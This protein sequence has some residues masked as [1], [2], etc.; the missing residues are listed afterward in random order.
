MIIDL[1]MSSKRL[2]NFL[3][4][5]GLL[6]GNKIK[7]GLDIPPW[8]N[9]RKTWQRACLRGLFDT[10]GCTYIDHHV[11]NGR[12]Y[13]NI[14][15]SFT[16]YSENLYDNYARI[17]RLLM[18]SPTQSAGKRVLLRRENEV[19]RFF[20]EIRPKNSRHWKIYNQFLEE[21]RSGYNGTA[22]KAVVSH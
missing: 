10:D 5:K 21:Y 4:R 9:S 7:Q 11:I 15:L 14:G 17:L 12:S 3:N 1:V 2:V 13:A 19:V 8:I 22:S 16:T 20:T 6:I 18:F